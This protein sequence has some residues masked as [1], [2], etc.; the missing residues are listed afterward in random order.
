MGYPEFDRCGFFRHVVNIDRGV[1]RRDYAAGVGAGV[2]F[3]LVRELSYADFDHW[4]CGAVRTIGD[5]R[6][7]LAVHR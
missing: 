3:C 5:L 2:F 4:V 7:V 6:P 1:R